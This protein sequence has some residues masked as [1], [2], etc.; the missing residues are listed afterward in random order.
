M[1]AIV[2]WT[3]GC[4]T[5]GVHDAR[6]IVSGELGGRF[7]AHVNA[8]FEPG[9]TA[10]P[11]EVVLDDGITEDEAV[12]LSL[13]NNASFQRLLSDL[14]VS[15]AQLLNAGLLTD[16]LFPIFF[17]LGPKQLEFAV[18]QPV[19]DLWLRPTRVRA[20]SLDLQ[21]VSQSMVQNGLNVIRDVR[22]AHSNYQLAARRAALLQEAGT[23]RND[24]VRLAQKRL[25]AGDISQLELMTSE[26][27]A[28]NAQ[29]AAAWADREIPVARE[30]LRVLIGLTMQSDQLDATDS[31]Q[32]HLPDQPVEELVAEALAARPDLRAA[33]IAIEAACE[34][35]GLTRQQFI[36]LEAVY[37]A[38]S[39]GHADRFESGPGLR[40]TIP[41]F[42]AN[43]GNIAIADAQWQQ[44][45]RQYFTVRDQI[46][47]DVRTAH[48]QLLQAH[49]NLQIIQQQVL[50]AL[51]T[52]E[53]LARK[54]YEIGGTTYFLVLQTT[55]QYI[56]ARIRELELQAGVRNALAE[57]ERSVGRRIVSGTRER[58]P[59]ANPEAVPPAPGAPAATGQPEADAPAPAQPIEARPSLVIPTAAGRQP[60]GIRNAEAVSRRDVPDVPAVHDSPRQAEPQPQQS[61]PEEKL[62]TDEPGQD[63]KHAVLQISIRFDPVGLFRR[64]RGRQDGRRQ[65]G[66]TRQD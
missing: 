7:A 60:A 51:K 24:I 17:P 64:L 30:R 36:R 56:D 28:L 55:G 50:P 33:E 20:A 1:A 10:V 44:A 62:G 47:L 46:V 61:R 34:R 23:L 59:R 53:E 29:A 31:G 35:V 43:R 22:V 65:E 15:R 66:R 9:A 49:E 18:F 58:V 26:I 54:N 39:R 16:P 12:Q 4:Q 5:A 3:S 11:P 2:L 63:R 21:S 38:N 41:I 48:A 25:E 32:P 42:N 6:G 37:D 8:P 57:L 40:F 52:A 14:G 27:D 13:W 45:A 19:E